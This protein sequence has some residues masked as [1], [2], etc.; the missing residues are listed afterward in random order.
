M[1]RRPNGKDFV[2]RLNARV[3]P[4]ETSVGAALDKLLHAAANQ[5]S[6]WL[7]GE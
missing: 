5:V 4:S 7:A 2:A 3:S 6:D 1:I